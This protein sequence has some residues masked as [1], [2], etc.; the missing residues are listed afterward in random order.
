MGSDEGFDTDL[1]VYFLLLYCD[2]NVGFLL[3]YGDVIVCPHERS[4]HLP[5]YPCRSCFRAATVMGTDIAATHTVRFTL[6]IK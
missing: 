4:C 6:S 5:H 2:V 1:I 3:L